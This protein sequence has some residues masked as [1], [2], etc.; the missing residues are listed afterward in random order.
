[1]QL[2]SRIVDFSKILKKFKLNKSN[3]TID[4]ENVPAGVLS[5][6]KTIKK[7][8]NLVENDSLRIE[9]KELTVNY[10]D[11]IILED[12]TIDK[13]SDTANI[14]MKLKK[15]QFKG[16]FSLCLTNS[17]SSCLDNEFEQLANESL[18]SWSAKL[19]LHDQLKFTLNDVNLKSHLDL[20]K[21]QTKI[22]LNSLQTSNQFVDKVILEF[23]KPH[24]YKEFNK[25]INFEIGQT[26]SSIYADLFELKKTENVPK[27][28]FM[29]DDSEFDSSAKRQPTNQSTIQMIRNLIN[30]P[31]MISGVMFK[32]LEQ[33]LNAKNSPKITFHNQDIEAILNTNLS[34]LHALKAKYLSTLKDHFETANLDP[35]AKQNLPTIAQPFFELIEGQLR[36][37]IETKIDGLINSMMINLNNH[38]SKQKASL[39]GDNLESGHQLH[40]GET[41]NDAI[42]AEF[43]HE[44]ENVDH[45]E[46][47]PENDEIIDEYTQTVRSPRT[48]RQVPCQRGQELDEYVDSLFRFAS[49]LVRA[50]E[51]VSLPNGKSSNDFFAL[52]FVTKNF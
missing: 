39:S 26:I 8:P 2:I 35:K 25:L 48:K 18:V 44:V 52:F 41:V 37:T 51:P 45:D 46:L 6:S 40:A 47:L 4:V 13:Q 15:I 23:I 32:F 33:N 27:I 7:W 11:R 20:T 50:M 28:D 5:I 17:T 22:R 10:L 31:S 9:L 43:D 24:L 3:S 14:L 42:S 30:L 29:P 21:V 36:E 49:R 38:M 34:T 12:A 16:R 19:I 1:M